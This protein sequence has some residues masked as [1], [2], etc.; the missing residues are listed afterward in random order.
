MRAALRDG[1]YDVVTRLLRGTYFDCPISIPPD[2][3]IVEPSRLKATALLVPALSRHPVVGRVPWLLVLDRE[4]LHLAAEIPCTDF[5]ARDFT[6]AEALARAERLM[7]KQLD[8]EFT[9]RSGPVSVDLRSHEAR[10][11]GAP[12]ALPPQEF[13]LLRHFV[14][15][16]G[17]A[18]DRD[19]LLRSVWGPDY[20]G[21]T[22][23]VDIHVRRLRAK[24]G[25]ASAHCLQTVRQIGYRWDPEG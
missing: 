19:A 21:G 11:S 13:A 24:L 20:L 10:L 6:P 23:T 16:P 25:E 3:V 17:R 9:V 14:Q 5:I 15:H 18:L 2:L 4:R 1:P 8:R 7:H 22:R 12:L